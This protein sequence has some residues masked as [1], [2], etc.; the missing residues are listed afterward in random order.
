MTTTAAAR[1]KALEADTERLIRSLSELRPRPA[2]R[3][4][5]RPGSPRARRIV[6]KGRG[7]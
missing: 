2:R 4:P 1:R 3:A 5:A 6:K 7:P